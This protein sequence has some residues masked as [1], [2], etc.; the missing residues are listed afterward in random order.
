[1]TEH[2]ERLD[3]TGVSSL[4]HRAPS[5]YKAHNQHGLGQNACCGKQAVIMKSILIWFGCCTLVTFVFVHLCSKL[6][7]INC[8][9]LNIAC[10]VVMA[11]VLVQYVL[12]RLLTFKHQ[13]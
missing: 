10:V 5:G 8:V 11:A 4:L 6:G 13:C 9:H 7:S 1:M 12:S 3:C 2:T